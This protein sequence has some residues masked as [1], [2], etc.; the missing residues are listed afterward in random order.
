[1]RRQMIVQ[2][3]TVS[4]TYGVGDNIVTAL[5]NV[6]DGAELTGS[7]ETVLTK[8]RRQRVGFVFQSRSALYSS[9]PDPLES[10]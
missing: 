7:T 6:T 1:M 9:S 5:D 4:K 10:G 2:L 3:D 8:F